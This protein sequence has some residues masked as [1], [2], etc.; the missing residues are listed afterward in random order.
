MSKT[1][2]KILAGC[3]ETSLG[4]TGTRNRN[5]S[6][7]LMVD[8]LQNNGI[9]VFEVGGHR[10]KFMTRTGPNLPTMVKNFTVDEPETLEWIDRYVTKGS[11]FW[12]IG[13]NVGLYTVYAGMTGAQV[14]AFEPS[15][16][17]YSILNQ[18]IHLNGLS[19]NV[20]AY[21]I[22]LS[23]VSGVER[24]YIKDLHAGNVFNTVGESANQFGEF[25][26]AFEQGIMSY[27]VDDFI[28]FAKIQPPEHVKLDVDGIEAK[29]LDGAEK[30][31]SGI[32]TL[33]I[34]VEG[35][36]NR[37]GELRDKI[38][39]FGLVDKTDSFDTKSTRNCLFVREE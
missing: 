18:Q 15:A 10:V 13:A 27:S 7:S 35:D 29:I 26:A 38:T 36:E 6:I 34:E 11:R 33:L 19:G 30:T 2:S 3:V 20:Q 39:S 37:Q 9:E 5:R 4:F 17:N 1:I 22:G 32:K 8:R 31:F 12:D 16:M 21:C 24:L 28:D 14:S 23:D 25:S